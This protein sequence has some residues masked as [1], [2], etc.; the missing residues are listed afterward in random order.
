L[1]ALLL[2]TIQ[3]YLVALLPVQASRCEVVSA[4]ASLLWPQAMWDGFVHQI[5]EKMDS[6]PRAS[7]LFW[8]VQVSCHVVSENSGEAV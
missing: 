7:R 6:H 3:A 8:D 2:L 4:V 1:V 5:P